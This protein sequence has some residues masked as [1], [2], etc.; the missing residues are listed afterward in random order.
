[1]IW[2]VG[3]DRRGKGLRLAST[4]ACAA[5]PHPRPVFLVI[6]ASA[7]PTVAWAVCLQLSIGGVLFSALCLV[8]AGEQISA[9][10]RSTCVGGVC[11][12]GSP[13]PEGLEP[14]ERLED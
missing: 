8:L 5:A 9:R 12:S 3:R 14:V 2:D 4:L 10:I 13:G 7:S 6:A 11:L 1:M